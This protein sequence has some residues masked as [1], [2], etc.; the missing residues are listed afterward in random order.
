MKD[1]RYPDKRGSVGRQGTSGTPARDANLCA[2]RRGPPP[3]GAAGREP[4]ANRMQTEREPSS[5]VPGGQCAR[6]Q[7]VVRYMLWS[8]PICGGVCMGRY[9]HAQHYQWLALIHER[10][11]MAFIFNSASVCGRSPSGLRAAH[12]RLGTSI[13]LMAGPQGG[14]GRAGIRKSPASPRT[15]YR[16][17]SD[18]Q[19]N[20]EGIASR[21][22]LS[23]KKVLD[24][25]VLAW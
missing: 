8:V 23:G 20:P 11:I 6:A 25:P 24:S 15:R 19:E 21:Y 12:T 1:R 7:G 13:S 4:T 9:A 14:S 22:T 2:S 16:S 17:L 10:R 18:A 3:R 5:P